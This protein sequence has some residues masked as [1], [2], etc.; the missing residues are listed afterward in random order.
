MCTPLDF[1]R[2]FGSGFDDSGSVRSH[3]TNPDRVGEWSEAFE[4]G[5][6]APSVAVTRGPY[7]QSTT[8]RSTIVAA[9]AVGL[10]CLACLR[11]CWICSAETAIAAWGVG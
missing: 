6:H 4:A 1:P 2:R 8:S 5:S 9:T 11:T 3:L 7:L 10:E